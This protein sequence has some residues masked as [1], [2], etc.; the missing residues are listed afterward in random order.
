MNL[1]ENPSEKKRLCIPSTANETKEITSSFCEKNKNHFNK[2]KVNAE[3]IAVCDLYPRRQHRYAVCCMLD[4]PKYTLWF[5]HT[6]CI[7]C[8]LEN[9]Y[10]HV[11]SFVFL[12]DSSDMRFAC[13]ASRL[14]TDQRNSNRNNE[15][16]RRAKSNLS[17]L[18]E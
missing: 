3:S 9:T 13:L 15:K 2:R 16:R 1:F 11:S 6:A 17:E 18:D 8:T 14:T 5:V 7:R 12:L 4:K 10:T